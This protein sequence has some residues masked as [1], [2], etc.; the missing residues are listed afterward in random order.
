M[1]ELVIYSIPSKLQFLPKLED[2]FLKIVLLFKIG[3]SQAY[4]NSL[5]PHPLSL[6][7]H[8]VFPVPPVLL[9]LVTSVKLFL[10]ARQE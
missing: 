6:S 9:L 10:C 1:T 5:F 3:Y 4:L 8:Q 7:R 2:F